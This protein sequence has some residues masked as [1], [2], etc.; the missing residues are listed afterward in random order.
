MQ[1]SPE[2]DRVPIRLLA[3]DGQVPPSIAPLAPHRVQWRSTRDAVA[4]VEGGHIVGKAAGEEAEIVARAFAG[5]AFAFNDHEDCGGLA[6]P[7]RVR[8]VV[9]LALQGLATPAERRRGAA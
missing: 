2:T 7:A 4:V 8:L 1:G 5:I 3:E 6:E 9:D